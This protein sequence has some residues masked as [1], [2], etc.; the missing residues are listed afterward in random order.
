MK[1]LFSLACAAFFIGLQF[2]CVSAAMDR[3]TGTRIDFSPGMPRSEV[4]AKLGVPKERR[5]DISAEARQDFAHVRREISFV[6]H[7]EFRGKINYGDDG[8]GQAMIGALTL[9]L[10]EVV[11]IPLTARD[12]AQ[13]SKETNLILVFFDAQERV[14]GVK[15]R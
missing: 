12:I 13:R 9:G 8:S 1:T 6:E 10:G 5:T 11:M 3:A 2:G 15:V 4:V 14:V 7:F